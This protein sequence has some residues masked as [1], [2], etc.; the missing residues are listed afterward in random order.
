MHMLKAR[1]SMA[2]IAFLAC[3]ALQLS[4]STAAGEPTRPML[5]VLQL[6]LCNSGLAGCYTGR[7]VAEA[8]AVIRANLP[9]VVT[10]NEV[11]QNDVRVL[12][13]QLQGAYAGSLVSAF[14]AAG[15]RPSDGVTL[16][17][18]GQPYGIGLLAH[19]RSPYRGYRTYGGVYST[20][21]TGDPEERAWLCVNAIGAFYACTTHLANTSST[22]AL[23]QC[24]YL[25]YTAIPEIRAKDGFLPTVV[26]GDFNLRRA[27]QACVPPGYLR[28]N[29]GDVQ[30][31]MATADFSVSATRL[32]DM[33][34]TTD[35]PG[36]LVT[37]Y[38]GLTQTARRDG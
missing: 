21:D 26:S 8:A 13:N 24:G 22:V 36:L 37:L 6:N 10:L 34:S 33:H 28:E 16:C 25:M 27:A 1:R 12:T 35:H 19:V 18:N 9:D 31:V 15:D 4:G 32:I 2:L 7:A 29:D 38:S 5:K 30:Q 14:R 3:G 11:C 17:R 23:G 20:Q